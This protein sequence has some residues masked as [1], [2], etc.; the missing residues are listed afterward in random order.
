MRKNSIW[1]VLAV[2]GVAGAAGI[3]LQAES[4]AVA[5]MQSEEAAEAGAAAPSTTPSEE[6]DAGSPQA[7]PGEEKAEPKAAAQA[8]SE[9]CPTTSAAKLNM[10]LRATHAFNQREIEKGREAAERA[11][12]GEIKEF[13]RLMVREHTDA[14]RRLTEYAKRNSV[15]LTKIAPVD[16]IHEALHRADVA[17][18]RML[19]AKREAGFDATY[20]APQ[21]FEHRIAISVVEEGQKYAKDEAKELL[22]GMHQML[23]AHLTIASRL[24]DNLHFAPAAVG[25]GPAEERGSGSDG[26]AEGHEADS[27]E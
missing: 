9:A 20:L 7:T 15:D 16:P 5:A 4:Q 24:I 25:G 22:D 3:A 11:Q 13:A 8:E 14:D 2:A 27:G 10:V 21:A 26:G 23:G 19:A 6:Q 12:A 1:A 18:Q 17:S